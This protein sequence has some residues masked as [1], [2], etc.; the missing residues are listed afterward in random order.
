MASRYEE[1]EWHKKLA[2]QITTAI[3]DNIS[4]IGIDRAD[5][6]RI[7]DYACGTGNLTKAFAPYAAAATGIDVSSGMIDIY[8]SLCDSLP[9][10]V[11]GI[12][13]DLLAE[14]PSPDPQFF[15]YDLIVVGLAY[16]HFENTA[17]AAKR[18][19][20]RLNPGGT[21]FIV[22]FLHKHSHGKHSHGGH[23]HN[24]SHDGHDHNHS[25]DV[26]DVPERVK[27][28]VKVL[29]FGEESVAKDFDDAGLSDFQLM[30]LPEKAVVMFGEKKTKRTVFFAKATKLV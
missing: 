20:E 5:K 25:H 19:A 7:L 11:S 9:F 21:L 30:V 17:E 3:Q 13:G 18:L 8:N 22:D 23:A 28:A 1:D 26:T 14:S 16:H 24:H 27:A 29:S 2:S 6:I 10:P 12:V 4:W 15:G